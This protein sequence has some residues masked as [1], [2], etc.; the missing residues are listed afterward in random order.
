M[1]V[2]AAAEAVTALWVEDSAMAQPTKTKYEADDMGTKK[3]ATSTEESGPGPSS[4][5]VASFSNAESKHLEGTDVEN[6]VAPSMSASY[7]KE[8]FKEHTCKK[9]LTVAFGLALFVGGCV[10]AASGSFEEW[11]V[12][13]IL[14]G[15]GLCLLSAPC[16]NGVRSIL[17][18]LSKLPASSIKNLTLSTFPLKLTR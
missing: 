3:S 2:P 14:C 1:T 15:M 11:W 9:L 5:N 16:Q 12:P 8:Q 4:G 10:G 6:G 13:L 18:A 17:L 7:L